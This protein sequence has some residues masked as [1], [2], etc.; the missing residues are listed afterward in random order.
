MPNKNVET[1][2]DISNGAGQQVNTEKIKCIFMSCHQ[3]SGHTHS[4]KIANKSFK[5]LAKLKCFGMTVTN[6]K[7]HSQTN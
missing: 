3:N 4:V 1:I 7:S 5:N 6:Q 2:K